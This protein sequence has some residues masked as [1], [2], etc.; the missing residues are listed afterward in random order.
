[1]GGV[2]KPF[3]ELGGEP[4]L[5]HALRP[6]LADHRVSTVVVALVDADAANPPEWLLV[7]SRVSVVAGGA[8]RSES[9]RRALGAMSESV[10]VIAVHD[11][12]RP[13]VAADVV[14]ACIDLAATGIGA[15]AGC[16]AVDTLKEVDGEG[17]VISTPDRERLWQAR[18]PQVFPAALLRRAYA[19]EAGD[20][21]D[22]SALVERL[23]AVVRM[24]DD[25]GENV[26][27]TRAS[28]LTFAESVLRLRED[29]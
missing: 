14:R 27:V 26:K 11:A 9:V 20:A 28:D 23:G 17:R 10:T 5:L 2:R 6:F 7:D 29:R 19:A 22:D 15:V 1:M 16:P 18:T 4:V 13:L 21:T 12:A 3:L 24:V 8:T 25:H